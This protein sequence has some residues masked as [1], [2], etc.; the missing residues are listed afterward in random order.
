MENPSPVV[1][2]SVQE[3][4]A[5]P[6]QQGG[7]SVPVLVHQPEDP[8]VLRLILVLLP[9]VLHK[10]HR[11]LLQFE[12]VNAAGDVEQLLLKVTKVGLDGKGEFPLVVDGMHPAEVF[13]ENRPISAALSTQ[14]V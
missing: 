4:V 11:R 5:S 7:Q 3:C 2:E 14:G 9:L 8:V 1:S 12:T 6:P 10:L 13:K